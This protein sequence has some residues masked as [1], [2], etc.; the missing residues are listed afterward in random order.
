MMPSL[1]V[2]LP[3]PPPRGTLVAIHSPVLQRARQRGLMALGCVRLA[4]IVNWNQYR[5]GT[6]PPQ[7]P[8]RRH[9]AILID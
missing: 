2:G 7:P 5:S 9:G 8:H 6:S 4:D 1:T 3:T